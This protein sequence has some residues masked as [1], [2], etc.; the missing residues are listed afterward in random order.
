MNGTDHEALQGQPAGRYARLRPANSKPA[1]VLA[2]VAASRVGGWT[3]PL[4]P[5]SRK[6]DAALMRPQPVI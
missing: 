1:G 4:P 2:L 5:P 3:P 6:V